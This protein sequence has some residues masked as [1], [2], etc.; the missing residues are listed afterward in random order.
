MRVAN[1]C[2]RCYYWPFVSNN[3]SHAQCAWYV[4]IFVWTLWH[5]TSRVDYQTYT[6]VFASD[7]PSRLPN[8]HH[9]I[10]IRRT[11]STTKPTR[12]YTW[13]HIYVKTDWYNVP[14][15]LLTVLCSFKST[16]LARD[17]NV[18][19]KPFEFLLKLFIREYMRVREQS[20]Y[21]NTVKWYYTHIMISVGLKLVKKPFRPWPFL[22]KLLRLVLRYHWYSSYKNN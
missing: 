8:L 1:W 13:P 14:I 22:V 7:E 12:C 11:E 19:I 21:L 17:S 10:G 18:P 4:F 16:R 2:R 20:I 5:Q 3:N 6:M 9:D 15:Q